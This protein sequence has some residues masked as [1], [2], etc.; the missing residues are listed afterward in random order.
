M[1]VSIG[2]DFAVLI[3]F[4]AAFLRPK[5][6]ST[7]REF[8]ENRDFTEVETPVLMTLLTG[9]SA[10]P[11]ITHHNSQDLDM[12]LRIALELNLKRLLVGGMEKVYEIG[13]TFRNEGM[14][15]EH[16]FQGSQGQ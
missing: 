5:I 8:L 16:L 11:F 1:K 9:A 7:I 14:D 2:F 13:R 15:E 6:I 12:Y 10:R 3:D 4:G